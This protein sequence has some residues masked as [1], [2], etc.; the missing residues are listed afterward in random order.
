MLGLGGVHSGKQQKQKGNNKVNSSAWWREQKEKR[1]IA[2][3]TW[4]SKRE[5]RCA[6]SG[7]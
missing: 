5:R 6:A 3:F 1:K 7:E 2:G 4:E